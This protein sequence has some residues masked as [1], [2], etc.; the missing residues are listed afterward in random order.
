MTKCYLILALLFAIG[1]WIANWDDWKTLVKLVNTKR[2]STT[3]VAVRNVEYG[4]AV[5]IAP[6]SANTSGACNTAIGVTSITINATSR[7]ITRT[8]E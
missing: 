2:F 8:D 6:L 4:E 5:G 3:M 1:S 7:Y